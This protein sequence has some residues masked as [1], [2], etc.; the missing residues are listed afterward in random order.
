MDRPFSFCLL[1]KHERRNLPS[2]PER[3]I[4]NSLIWL[5]CINKD[6]LLPR[7]DRQWNEPKCMSILSYSK[8]VRICVFHCPS[9]TWRSCSPS[10]FCNDRGEN[11]PLLVGC[12]QTAKSGRMARKK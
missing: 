7:C 11:G 5:Y 9:V 6:P 8:S 1:A 2:W 12:Q 3:A 10:E 4:E